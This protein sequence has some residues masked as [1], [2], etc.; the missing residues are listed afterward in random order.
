[1]VV[2]PQASS[3]PIANLA[4]LHAAAFTRELL[5]TRDPAVAIKACETKTFVRARSCR[6]KRPKIWNSAIAP[7]GA[8]WFARQMAIYEAAR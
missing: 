1:M 4:M 3:E 6:G 7:D 8:A 5:A 2:F